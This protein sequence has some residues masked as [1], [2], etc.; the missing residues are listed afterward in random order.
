MR[1]M[2]FVCCLL[3]L[4]CGSSKQTTKESAKVQVHEDVKVTKMSNAES[5]I[6]DVSSDHSVIRI[7][8]KRTRFNP[9]TADGK[10]SI[11]DTDERTYEKHN[12]VSQNKTE[13]K[14]AKELA[15]EA[16]RLRAKY[17]DSCKK[18]SEIKET[19]IPQQIG[20]ACAGVVLLII[21]CWLVYKKR[22]R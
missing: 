16:K 3:L 1:V 13:N 9:P 12:D 5:V 10:Q 6:T 14:K 18:S 4:G 15:E 11:K 20:N 21:I 17:E 7:T 2:W 19:T 8:Y 22:N